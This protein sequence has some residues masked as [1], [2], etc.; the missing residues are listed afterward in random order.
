MVVTTRLLLGSHRL[1]RNLF[2]D[3]D[4]RRRHAAVFGIPDPD[5]TVVAAGGDQLSARIG[6]QRVNPVI[7]A[8]HFTK[9][10]TIGSLMFMHSTVAAGGENQIARKYLNPK[11][12]TAKT[13]DRTDLFGIDRIQTRRRRS[14]PPLT[15]V[16]LSARKAA[17]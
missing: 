6:V 11:N 13:A 16:V 2:W 8:F 5:F 4:E 1:T 7:V 9:F 3:G 10:G 14:L 17:E 15:T 12:V